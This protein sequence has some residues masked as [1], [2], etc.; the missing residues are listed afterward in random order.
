V[1]HVDKSIVLGRIVLSD[2]EL[3][4]PNLR[5]H[6]ALLSITVSIG[7]F[8][9]DVRKPWK[10]DLV[11]THTVHFRTTFSIVMI[12]KTSSSALRQE[13]NTG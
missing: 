3:S 1:R 6:V 9:P 2:E 12:V 13:P 10:E 5:A 4:V 7:G 11:P 8:I